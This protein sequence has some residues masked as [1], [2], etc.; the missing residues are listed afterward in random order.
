MCAKPLDAPAP[1]TTAILAGF[2]DTGISLGAVAQ[3]IIM[4]NKTQAQIAPI[5]RK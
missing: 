4:T 3:E 5:E 1:S 2:G